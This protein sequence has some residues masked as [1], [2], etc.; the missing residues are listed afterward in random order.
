MERVVIYSVLTALKVTSRTRKASG[1]QRKRRRMCGLCPPAVGILA[2]VDR[3]SIPSTTWSQTW[4]SRQQVAF[5]CSWPSPKWSSGGAVC[6]RAA[7]EVATVFKAGFESNAAF[8]Y[9][10]K[11]VRVTIIP[12]FAVVVVVKRHSASRARPVMGRG[13]QGYTVLPVL[14]E[15][16]WR[17]TT[18][19]YV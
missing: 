14:Y 8:M 11:Q 16:R 9:F 1:C 6:G 19:N 12:S 4:Q 18:R 17:R 15:Y 13:V 5:I 2:D 7:A 10:L 3:V